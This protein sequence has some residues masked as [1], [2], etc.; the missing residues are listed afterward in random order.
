MMEREPGEG[1]ILAKT[2]LVLGKQ[3]EAPGLGGGLG[4]P[5]GP[6]GQAAVCRASS[7]R[8]SSRCPP[9]SPLPSME[10][11]PHVLRVGDSASLGTGVQVPCALVSPGPDPACSSLSPFVRREPRDRQAPGSVLLHDSQLLAFPSRER[12][13]LPHALK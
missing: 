6:R 9:A 4:E 5:E 11:A 3:P 7:S 2:C 10:V 12:S 13:I 1:H 8:T